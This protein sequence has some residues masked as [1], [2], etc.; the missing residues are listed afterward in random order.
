MKAEGPE[1]KFAPTTQ[2]PSDLIIQGGTA[3]TMVPN[4][5]PIPNARILIQNDRITA[6]GPSSEVRSRNGFLKGYFRRKPSSSHRK[7][8][9]GG[10]FWDVLK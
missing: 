2:K 3:V 10:R 1:S 4:Q 6:I 9:T 8:F 5:P 7:R